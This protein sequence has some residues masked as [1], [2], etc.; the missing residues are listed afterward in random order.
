[1][2]LQKLI[3]ERESV[4]LLAKY[5]YGFRFLPQWKT[6]IWI[7]LEHIKAKERLSTIFTTIG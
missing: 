5:K 4:K 1:V 3:K 7:S 2:D 6:R